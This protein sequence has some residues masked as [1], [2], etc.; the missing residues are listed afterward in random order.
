MRVVL[1][2]LSVK[3]PYVRLQNSFSYFDFTCLLFYFSLEVQKSFWPFFSDN[4]RLQPPFIGTVNSQTCRQRTLKQRQVIFRHAAGADQ[5]AV[6]S[7]NHRP[8]ITILQKLEGNSA[9]RHCTITV[10][11]RM[12]RRI[13]EVDYEPETSAKSL[14]GLLHA[15]FMAYYIKIPP[16]RQQ[17]CFR[18]NKVEH[19]AIKQ[20]NVAILFKS[21]ITSWVSD[22]RSRSCG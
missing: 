4:R 2:F 22:R 8:F 3:T 5:P 7:S 21:G 9:P 19:W 17:T 14:S 15:R 6:L 18:L 10:I 12:K 1:P 16:W 11:I 20:P 13:I